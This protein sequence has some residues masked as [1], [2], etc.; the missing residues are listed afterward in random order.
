MTG[1]Q[2]QRRA[3]STPLPVADGLPLA[4][5]GPGARVS[6]SV[7]APLEANGIILDGAAG[8]IVTVAID[9]LF[10]S[11]ELSDE[12]TRF[13]ALQGHEIEFLLVVASHTHY[14]PSLD[15]TKP[16]I[17]EVDGHYFDGVVD[18]IGRAIVTTLTE[19][20]NG[21]ARWSA[22]RSPC[23]QNVLR[24]RAR[25][26]PQR[27]LTRSRIAIAPDTSKPVRHD[28]D[29]VVVSDDDGVTC[30]LWTWPCHA[31]NEP[32]PLCTSSDFPGRVRARLRA[33]T[34]LPNL[35]VLF[36]PGFAGDQRACNLTRARRPR[37]L[38]TI[39]FGSIFAANSDEFID[40]IT[41]DLHSAI[42]EAMASASVLDV[43]G[44]ARV[45]S[46]SVPLT[47]LLADT[48]ARAA[49]LP[50]LGVHLLTQGL[51][52]LLTIGAEVCE[53]YYR[54]LSEAVPPGTLMTGYAGQV[55]GYLPS[56]EQRSE[57]GYEAGD[58]FE[59]FSLNGQLREHLEHVVVAA[60]RR[61]SQA[62]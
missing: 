39:G 19:Q 2:G 7:G 37:D 51:F 23:A 1:A 29:V 32:N 30:I 60:V 53:P 35:P 3:F 11:D 59:L 4:G 54:I 33:D 8:P 52:N 22:G 21:D 17:G 47:D 58:Y 25:A 24:R 46:T 6:T 61:V 12:I 34:G 27:L 57:G 42:K 43:A 14:A 26:W 48:G 50:P 9:C 56:D 20:S 38:A 15:R 16:L 18:A 62:R 31:V 40:R 5:Y 28:V 13:V 55:F 49:A 41:A 10:A 36:L 44:P 45:A